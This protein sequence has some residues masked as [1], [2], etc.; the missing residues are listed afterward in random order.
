[1]KKMQNNGYHKMIRYMAVIL[2]LSILAL[3]L[4]AEPI[5]NSAAA[6]M[7]M[8][9]GARVIAMGEAGTTI[10]RDIVSGY[11][12]PAGLNMLKD[13]EIGTMYNFSMNLDRSHMYAA[14]GKPFAF[15]TM[16]LNWVS[17]GTDDND[18][19]DDA[20]NPTGT[21]SD[22]NNALSISYA[23]TYKR[24]AYGLT[25]KL[26]FNS[27]DGDTETGF[28]VDLG[29]KYDVNQYIEAGLMMRD[30]VGTLA[31][32]RIPFEL[33]LGVAAYP[34]IGVTVA[35]DMKWE[36]SEN[37]YL[38]VG[39]EY[40][41]SIGKDPEADSKLSVISVKERSTWEEMFSYAQTGVR[42][43]FNQGRFSAG[44]GIRFRNFQLDYVFRLNNNDI[45]SDDHIVSMIFRF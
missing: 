3:P 36:Q 21:F 14:V 42:L 18:G 11:W 28:G 16:A 7:R 44:T 23:N 1:M 32:D 40:W 24:L 33:S 5:N 27:M 34:L 2:L 17:A 4:A 20:G 38:A 6:F 29:A 25:P 13:I 37:P 45:M 12:N 15:G 31:G 8:G 30:L 41:T 19:Y 22:T 43:G 35:A 10:S 39:A 26:Y 9:V